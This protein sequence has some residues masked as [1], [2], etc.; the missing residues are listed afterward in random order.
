MES[1]CLLSQSCNLLCP[2]ILLAFPFPIFASLLNW[3]AKGNLVPS[4]GPDLQKGHF[5]GVS[6]PIGELRALSLWLTI[7]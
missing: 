6:I 2:L 7:R 1:Y 3:E 5:V 4:T